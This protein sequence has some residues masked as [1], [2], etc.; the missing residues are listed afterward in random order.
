MNK[1]YFAYI[2]VSTTKQG[3]RGSSLTEQ[4]SAI[5]GYASRNGLSVV[6]WFEEMETA[7]KQGR[8]KFS[9]MM[10]QLRVGKADGIIIHKIDR[11]SRNPRDWADLGD[12]VDRGVDV[13]FVSDNFDLFSRGGRLSADIQA[14]VAVDYIR[15]LREEVKKGM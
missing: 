13:R 8:R 1:R 6:G 10:A 2:R 11:G 12:L 5:E 3:E 9:E 7:A 15:N 4:K 14:V